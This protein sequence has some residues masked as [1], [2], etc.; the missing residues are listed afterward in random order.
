MSISIVIERGTHLL[1]RSERGFAV[2][3][4]RDGKIYATDDEGRAPHPDTAEG[5]ETAVHERWRDENSARQLFED[6]E[7]KGDE[8]A[9]RMR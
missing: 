3:E 9:Q 6:I 2:V 4:R 5:I 1:V 8:L 7:V